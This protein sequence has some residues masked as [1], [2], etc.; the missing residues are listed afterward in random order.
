M[1]LA[2]CCSLLYIDL[3]FVEPK[4]I[5]SDHDSDSS[6]QPIKKKTKRFDRLYP[7]WEPEKY[8]IYGIP[9][10]VT[11]DEALYM[12][13]P[14]PMVWDS[15][16][17]ASL[18]HGHT[19]DER[20]HFIY[21]FRTELWNPS[22]KN[23]FFSHWIQNTNNY[24]AGDGPLTF[25]SNLLWMRLIKAASPKPRN[26]LLHIAYA[27]DTEGTIVMAT[28]VL[29]QPGSVYATSGTT[30]KG[31]VDSMVLEQYVAALVLNKIDP[32][33]KGLLFRPNKEK[34][35]A[36]VDKWGQAQE[37]SEVE[38]KNTI[39]VCIGSNRDKDWFHQTHTTPFAQDKVGD[40]YPSIE[41]SKGNT[42]NDGTQLRIRCFEI[43]K[44]YQTYIDRGWHDWTKAPFWEPP[45]SMSSPDSIN[46]PQIPLVFCPIKTLV[47]I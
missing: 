16:F 7:I 33:T 40:Y 19:V 38:T 6:S 20:P 23:D 30:V 10:T 2:S 34:R 24:D 37:E 31:G 44:R 47:Q 28:C 1:F 17:L 45:N 9:A 5:M 12:Q 14:R 46:N 36:M 8:L 43:S 13:P 25:F 21:T 18:V 4:K 35:D 22:L 29:V 3:C 15:S 42:T 39:G 32:P 11:L 27:T 41:F 26:R